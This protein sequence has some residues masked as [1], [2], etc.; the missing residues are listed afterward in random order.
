[1]QVRVVVEVEH[2]SLSA[3]IHWL[4]QEEEV[5]LDSRLRVYQVPSLP[6]EPTEAAT[7]QDWVEQM[8]RVELRPQVVVEVLVSCLPVARLAMETT[9]VV[10]RLLEAGLVDCPTETNTRLQVVTVV[11]E[12][13]V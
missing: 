1:M 13:V 12:P 4:L 11:E 7:F 2:S 3:V 8:D 6:R 9:K 10:N 5:E